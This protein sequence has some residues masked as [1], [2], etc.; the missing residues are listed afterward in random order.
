MAKTASEL[1]E[2]I[3]EKLDVLISKSDTI[4]KLYTNSDT[5]IKTSNFYL[6]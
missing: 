3:S 5:N 6:S 4:I 1:L 2:E